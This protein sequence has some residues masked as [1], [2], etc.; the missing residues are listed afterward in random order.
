MPNNKAIHKITNW[1]HFS[2]VLRIWIW[3]PMWWYSAVLPD[4]KRLLWHCY[5]TEQAVYNEMRKSSGTSPQCDS[6]ITTNKLCS[7]AILVLQIESHP[8]GHT[9]KDYQNGCSLLCTGQG[10]HN[11]REDTLHCQ[12]Q[13]SLQ[14]ASS[15]H[16]SLLPWRKDHLMLQRDLTN[17]ESRLSELTAVIYN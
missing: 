9:F 13:G 16:P 1:I 10:N 14:S 12:Q 11:Y 17:T 8:L 15:A 3:P 7:K 5:H 2:G 6:T 4:F